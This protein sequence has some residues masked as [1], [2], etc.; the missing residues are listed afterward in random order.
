[1][2]HRHERWLDKFFLDQGLADAAHQVSWDYW[3][4]ANLLDE[5]ERHLRRPHKLVI[6][7][8]G[9]NTML[10]ITDVQKVTASV[11]LE[12]AA[13]NPVTPDPST[14][15]ATPSW[16]VSD[17]TI[18]NLTPNPDGSATLVS[19]GKLGTSQVSVTVGGLS[20]TD[21]VEVIAS[22][23]TQVGISFGTPA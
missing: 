6:K 17:S 22:A 21:S 15:S 20:A 8:T 16:A 1:V 5:Y 19:T 2:S 23:A 10:R 18:L 7:F 3:L 11:V 13:G 4:V 12:D 9:G 14:P